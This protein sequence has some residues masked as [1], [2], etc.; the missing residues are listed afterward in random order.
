MHKIP[1]NKMSI[2]EVSK[3]EIHVKVYKFLNSLFDLK[4]T[5][6]TMA[7]VIIL[8]IILLIEICFIRIISFYVTILECSENEYLCDWFCHGI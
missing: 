1:I 6:L 5:S 4:K 8:T 7:L 3:N 2:L